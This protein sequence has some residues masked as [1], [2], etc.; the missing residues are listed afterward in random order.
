MGWKNV[1]DAIKFL[2]KNCGK[3][4]RYYRNEAEYVSSIKK[5]Y[6]NREI[7]ISMDMTLY[8][9]SELSVIANIT[10]SV[11]G[12]KIV[13]RLLK[14]IT[15]YLELAPHS[16][17]LAFDGSNAYRPKPKDLSNRPDHSGERFNDVNNILV[18]DNNFP[19]FELWL[20]N[21]SNDEFK[22]K[23]FRYLC[24]KIYKFWIDKKITSRLI[25]DNGIAKN[26]KFCRLD[27]S[28]YKE[29]DKLNNICEG[30]NLMFAYF[31]E[32][33]DK[34]ND[35]KLLFI[36]ISHDSDCIDYGNLLFLKNNHKKFDLF[37]RIKIGTSHANRTLIE[38]G[39]KFLCINIKIL[40][41]LL[42]EKIAIPKNK[43]QDIPTLILLIIGMFRGN[44]FVVKTGSKGGLEVFDPTISGTTFRF[45]KIRNSKH[46]TVIESLKK[47]LN[48][49]KN[50]TLI[51]YGKYNK[52]DIIWR[53]ND[54]EF[55]RFIKM[56]LKKKLSKKQK[57]KMLASFRNMKWCLNYFSNPGKDI[58]VKNFNDKKNNKSTYGYTVG[59]N[60]ICYQTLNI[61]TKCSI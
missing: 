60:G 42:T 39:K 29:T 44:D 12:E 45:N 59:K 54:I 22:K 6:K 5:D 20:K 52:T 61:F 38:K 57:R 7:H 46:L 34:Q 16:I 3:S 23:V 21:K 18:N 17:H 55:M 58:Y 36:A 32:C 11:K 48:F 33:L 1:K 41:K 2:K 8:L 25:I 13:S 10:G 47:Y 26:N 30:E 40:R 51:S 49:K 37:L 43:G 53:I 27:S 24:M 50:R 28:C 9:M 4:F 35:K 15:P 14:Y 19:N 31:Q 56:S